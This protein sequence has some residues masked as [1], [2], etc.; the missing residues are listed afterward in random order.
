MRHRLIVFVPLLL[1]LTSLVR[2]AAGG[3]KLDGCDRDRGHA[4][5]R[6]PIEGLGR[7][8]GRRRGRS[9]GNPPGTGRAAASGWNG[10]AV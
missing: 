3:R 4:R 8:R 6:F 7:F 10:P 2:P 1:S 5:F 9:A